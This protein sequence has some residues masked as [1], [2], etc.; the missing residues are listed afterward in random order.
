MTTSNEQPTLENWRDAYEAAQRIKVM[1]PWRYMEETDIFAVQHPESESLGFPS[2]MGQLG[3]H[4]A[5]SVYLG[6]EGLYAFWDAQDADLL[7]Y[8]DRLLEMPQLMLS[9]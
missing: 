7:T 6:A 4:F 5:V 9:F 1:E 2:V 3:E 8:P